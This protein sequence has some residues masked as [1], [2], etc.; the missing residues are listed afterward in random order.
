MM[1]KINQQF[2]SFHTVMLQTM[3]VLVINMIPQ[4]TN[5]QRSV[6]LFSSPHDMLNTQPPN[7]PHHGSLLTHLYP[8]KLPLNQMTQPTLHPTNPPIYTQ[9]QSTQ[10]T[11]L[12]TNQT[13]PPPLPQTQTSN[14]SNLPQS[15]TSF[16]NTMTAIDNEL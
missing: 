8:P 6:L 14:Y 5:Q 16:E 2:A 1:E 7:Y 12:T 3:K 13:F 11:T 9:P 15:Q 10:D 4:I